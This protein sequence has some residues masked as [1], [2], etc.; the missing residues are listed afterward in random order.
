[1]NKWS[2]LLIGVIL[3]IIAVL[4]VLMTW[5][6]GT[7]DFGTATWEF[8]KGGLMWFIF[9]IGLLFV[10]LGIA[11]LKEDMNK[12]TRS[13]LSRPSMPTQNMPMVTQTTSSS[14]PK[15]RGRPSKR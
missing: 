15:K 9:L 13:N 4:V 5:G 7:W 11:D 12:P 1:M 3:V 6:N 8:F 2:E 14:A 10:M